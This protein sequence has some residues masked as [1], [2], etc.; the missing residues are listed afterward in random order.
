MKQQQLGMN[1]E[2]L[3]QLAKANPKYA[4]LLGQ[5]YGIDKIIKKSISETISNKADPDVYY[6][7]TELLNQCYNIYLYNRERNATIGKGWLFDDFL[8]KCQNKTIENEII[9]AVLDMIKKFNS[10]EKLRTNKINWMI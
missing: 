7:K 10:S 4:K 6:I 2:D 3:G 1:L 5:I 8:K 9:L